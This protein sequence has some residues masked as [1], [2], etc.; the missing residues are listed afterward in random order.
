LHE[1]SCDPNFHLSIDKQ[2]IRTLFTLIHNL[3]H[4]FLSIYRDRPVTAYFENKNDA[5]GNILPI[6]TQPF[7]FKQKR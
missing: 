6:M 2:Q 4:L 1:L 5:I 7:D 3:V